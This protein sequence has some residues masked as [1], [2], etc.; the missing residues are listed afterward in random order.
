M[1]KLINYFLND[2]FKQ[3]Q[4]AEKKKKKKK[5]KKILHL[6]VFKKKNI[7]FLIYPKIF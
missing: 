1:L 7:I 4:K 5:K 2:Y 3:F 6:G